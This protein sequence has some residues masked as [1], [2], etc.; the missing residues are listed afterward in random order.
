MEMQLPSTPRSNLRPGPASDRSFAPGE[1]SG[2]SPALNWHGL[3]ARLAAAAA[4]REALGEAPRLA[5][6]ANGSF[7]PA[8]A[9]R[10]ARFGQRSPSAAAGHPHDGGNDCRAVNRTHSVDL[11]PDPA[12]GSGTAG[13]EMTGVR[14]LK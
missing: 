8:S 13:A 9:R 3:A 4:C 10:L 1:S 11:K 7:D 14:G 12:I 2:E 5:I 6:G